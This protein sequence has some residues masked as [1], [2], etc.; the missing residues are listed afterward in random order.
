MKTTLLIDGDIVA[1]KVAARNE[2]TYYDSEIKQDIYLCNNNEAT[3]Q[4]DEFLNLLTKQLKSDTM[5]VLLSDKKNFRKKVLPSY[6]ENR[7]GQRKPVAL[8]AMRQYL[9]TAYKAE[10]WANLEAD[11][12]IG[13]LATENTDEKRIMV[14]ID[15]DF[16]SVPGWLF[17]PD[18]DEAPRLITLEKANHKFYT[19]VMTGDA[20]DG[21]KG[22]PGLGPKKVEKLLSWAN[23]ERD[24]WP[25]IKEAFIKANLTEED[26]LVQARCA[27][28]LRSQD[29]DYKKKKAILWKPLV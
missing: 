10:K 23:N 2:Y 22:I 9:E 6:K 14:S 29:Y 13:I 8:G 18:K 28:I 12:V 27:R 21:Y 25:I 17:N 11:D 3:A 5:R 24:Y 26:A 16:E 7:K 1:Y 20:V 19:Q 4:I 15:K